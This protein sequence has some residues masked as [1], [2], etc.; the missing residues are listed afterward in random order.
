VER[1]VSHQW[2]PD[3]IKSWNQHDWIHMPLRVGDQIGRL[4]GAAPRQTL[5]CDSISVNLFKVL[6]ASLDQF[7]GH[8]ILSTKDNFP[9]DLY[10][11]QGIQKLLAERNIEL[12][13]VAESELLDAIDS[14]VCAV[15]VT[16]VN[17]RTGALLNVSALVEKAHSAH[18]ALILDLAHSAGA[19]PVELDTWRVDFAVGCTYKYLNAGPGAP[20]FLYVA[21]QHL[22]KAVQPLWGWMG[23]ANPFAFSPQYEPAKD[24]SQFLTGTPSILAMAAVE[25]AL[26]V[27]E[28]INLATVREKSLQLSQAFE[29]ELERRGLLDYMPSISPTN[30]ECRGS[31]LS[32]AHE[33]AYAICQA[34]IA[35]GVI[36]DF[37]AP[38][39]LRVGFTPLYLSFEE[40]RTAIDK[41]EHIM[42]AEI[43]L[44]S[45]FQQRQKVT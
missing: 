17:F 34:W 33:H 44:Q 25:G 8:V 13:L 4:I 1:I 28:G 41:L 14:S 26:K 43:Y 30:V 27:F 16:Q 23:H 18:A 10:M 42:T 39:Y 37:R 38:N 6:C 32:F 7:P 22:G 5:C 21:Q 29:L 24:I 36:A 2:G 12:K 11:V 3:L 20:A 45:Q 40:L 15:L 35:A 19:V 31:Q 9:T